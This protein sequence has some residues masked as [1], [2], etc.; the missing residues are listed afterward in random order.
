MVGESN[1]FKFSAKENSPSVIF[2]L[3]LNNFFNVHVLS[4]VFS[5]YPRRGTLCNNWLKQVEISPVWMIKN[6][7][8]KTLNYSERQVLSLSP[9]F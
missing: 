9:S 1:F 8:N 3:I 6:K 2:F 5:L 7:Q 4:V